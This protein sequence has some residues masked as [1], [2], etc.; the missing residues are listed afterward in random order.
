MGK[1]LTRIPLYFT[2]QSTECVLSIAGRVPA[3]LTTPQPPTKKGETLPPRRARWKIPSTPSFNKS[4]T[5][6]VFRQKR[7]TERMSRRKTIRRTLIGDKLSSGRTKCAGRD[8]RKSPEGVS[9]LRLVGCTDGFNNF[10]AK[11]CKKEKLD[12]A[13]SVG[14]RVLFRFAHVPS[15]FTHQ[16]CRKYCALTI[17]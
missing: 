13:A 10:H 9:S 12:G 1:T 8:G 2:T 6:R 16:M 3:T 5:P 7:V 17:Q 15:W 14:V 4:T 11:D